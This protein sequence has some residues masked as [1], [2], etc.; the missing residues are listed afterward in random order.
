MTKRLVTEEHLSLTKALEAVG[1]PKST[2]YYEARPQ[3]LRSLNPD[4][5]AALDTLWP[6]TRGVYGYRKVWIALRTGGLRVNKKAV[7]RHLRVM[8]GK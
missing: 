4:L 1:M 8:H 6:Q 3:P 7:L 2:W 5:V